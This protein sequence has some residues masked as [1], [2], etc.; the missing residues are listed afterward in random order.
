MDKECD[1]VVKGALL[2]DIGKVVQRASE[3]PTSRRH[4]EW[5]YEWL[6]EKGFDEKIAMASIVH[7]YHKDYTFKT[8]TSLIWYQA[9]K[10]ASGERK[11]IE[12]K[13]IEEPKWHREVLLASP[14]SRVRNPVNKEPVEKLTYLPLK[15]DLTLE[16]VL[17][18][19]PK[20]I[21]SPEDYKDLLYAF[22]EDLKHGKEHE[23]PLNFLL[24]LFEK[25]FS[26]VPSI[27]LAFYSRKTK[28]EL[29]S[30]H[31]DIS[32]YDHSKLTAAI[33]GCMSHYY[34]ER[35][36]ERWNSRVLKDEILNV[37]E[38]ERPYLLIGGDISGIQKF[39]YTITSKGALK[40]L[41]GRSFFLELLAEHCV[42]EL[43]KGLSLTR[44]NLIFSGGGHFY[45]LGYNTTTAEK[46]INDFKERINDFLFKEFDGA[47]KAHI[48]YESFHPD[49]FSKKGKELS[50]LWSGLSEKLE[51]SKKKK[52]PSR[53][54]EF[55]K[56]RM[57]YE[58]KEDEERSCLTRSCN[59]CFREDLPLE[60][61]RE[62]EEEI[63]VCRPCKDQ[64]NLGSTLVAISKGDSP[65]LYKFSKEPHWKDYIRIDDKYYV[66]LKSER[67]DLQEGVE[68]IYRIN[69][70]RAE[71]YSHPQAVSLPLG[72]Y[73]DEEMQELSD[74]SKTYGIK[75]IAVLRMDVDNLG[76]IFSEAIPEEDRTFSRMASISRRLN[77]FF[78]YYL[79]NIME[80]KP[81]PTCHDIAERDVKEHGRRLSIVYS[82][83]DDL[84]IIGH[85]LDVIEASMDI[86]EY[87][88]RFT[89]NPYITISGGIAINHEK[90]PVYQYARDA[91]S[92]EERAKNHKDEKGEEKNAILFFRDIPFKWPEV[93]DFL[94]RLGLFICFLK[95]Q[96]DQL[97]V[98]EGKLPR[99]FFY[100][101][102]SLARRFREEDILLLPKAAYLISRAR[103]GNTQPEE[104]LRIK[105]V[106]MTTNPR[107]WKITEAATL[108]IL[109]MMRKGG[110]RDA[111]QR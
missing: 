46:A 29:K 105:E 111:A 6:K 109:M 62:E 21:A 66:L 108:M 70:Y 94:K 45:I 99:T 41:K 53:L 43:I 59:V 79:N 91:G 92:A 22:E 97:S 98:D 63:R 23:Y 96:K 9:D 88:H 90:Y 95:R 18:E 102:L 71:H 12:D 85:W 40:S 31:P 55:L 28:E 3:G 48:E 13:E 44:C 107:E 78:K 10:L 42:S 77:E 82:G 4:T 47:L 15:K 20:S 27:T 80:A 104:E 51:L 69:D 68:A 11:D 33:A 7:H 50:E 106:I 83:G 101:L 64:Y 75:R 38:Q 65:V 5:G 61:L 17:E 81:L 37:P 14:F 57:P 74:V 35:Y 89:G 34:K 30:K 26:N 103:F 76:R 36:P 25:H 84:F 72:T 100:R 32:L 60:D 8:N 56:P 2:H 93:K 16:E 24:M 54:E 19:D 73:Q 49:L 87:F 86:N 110:E 67:E 39:I 58:D 1:T 52:W